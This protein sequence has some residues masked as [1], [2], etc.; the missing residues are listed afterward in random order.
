[1]LIALLADG[2]LLV[3]G[4]PGLLLWLRPYRQRRSHLAALRKAC[5]SGDPTGAKNALLKWAAS[6][7]G[8][9]V[10]ATL[11]ALAGR[12]T[13]IKARSA[14]LE[15]DAV[16]YGQGTRVWNAEHARRRI[17]KG[18]HPLQKNAAGKNRDVVPE[19]NP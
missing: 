3:E 18:L 4:A 14:L 11:L 13:D 1:M 19:L 15:L 17:L 6:F 9:S 2:H 12:L 16:L 8:D 5:D 7:Q 10:P